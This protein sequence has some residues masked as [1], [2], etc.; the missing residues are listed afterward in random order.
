MK[1]VDRLYLDNTYLQTTPR[2]FLV[3]RK[4][5]LRLKNS[6]SIILVDI[7]FW[8]RYFGKRGRFNTLI[9]EIEEINLC[10]T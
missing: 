5:Y 4:Q 2:Y 6:W 7:Y 8:L 9:K 10:R 1:K 3:K